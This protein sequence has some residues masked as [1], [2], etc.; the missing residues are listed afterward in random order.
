MTAISFPNSRNRTT[1]IWRSKGLERL[2]LRCSFLVGAV[3]ILWEEGGG[4]PLKKTKKHCKVSH[5][6][7]TQRAI[8]V[9]LDYF[10]T[11]KAKKLQKQ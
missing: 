5:S 10:C 2:L 8:L 9:F 4:H 1:L 6:M 3:C 11:A 7:E